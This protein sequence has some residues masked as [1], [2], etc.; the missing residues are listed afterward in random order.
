MEIAVHDNN[1]QYESGH[2][3]TLERREWEKQEEH[4][5]T[6]NQNGYKA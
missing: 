2:T 1:T 6:Y 5:I 3:E 4:C